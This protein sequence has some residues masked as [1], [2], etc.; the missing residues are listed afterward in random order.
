MKTIKIIAITFTLLG[1]LNT[2]VAQ[3]NMQN[4][5][6][7]IGTQSWSNLTTGAWCYYNNDYVNGTTYGKLYNWYAVAG[8]L[9]EAS[10]TDTT[11]RK[12][13]SPTGY[14][15]PYDS[16]WTTLTTF[17]GGLAVAGGKMKETGTAH[18]NSP[19]YSANISS[20]FTG[21]PGGWRINIGA[22][23]TIGS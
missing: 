23:G 22:F 8:I 20:G 13:L 12:K 5:L 4:D 15:V 19:N 21:L 3:S 10:K 1:F 11:Q 9:S 17:L 7:N 6:V 16:E 14:H 18:W 2:I